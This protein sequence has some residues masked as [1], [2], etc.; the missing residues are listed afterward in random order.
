[1]KMDKDEMIIKRS[2]SELKRKIQGFDSLGLKESKEIFEYVY[3]NQVWGGVGERPFSGAGSHLP[4]VVNPYVKAVLDEFPAGQLSAVDVGCGDFSVGSRI[5]K[6]FSNYTALDV[7]PSIISALKKDFGA[8]QGLEFVV[9]DASETE[10]P[11]ADVYFVREVFQHL[12]NA[13][14]QK[15]LENLKNCKW[16]VLTE[17]IPTGNF[18]PNLD[19]P[20]GPF[21]RLVRMNSG[22]KL[23]ESPFHFDYVSKKI[24]LQIPWRDGIR[25]TVVYKIK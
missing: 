23:E 3:E 21:S 16:L 2:K 25:E 5:F 15:I 22:V 24:V 10:T 14:I 13:T 8:Q 20:T 17:V 11:P 12:S 1:M 7:V 19:Q 4:E 9:H 18:I 6:H